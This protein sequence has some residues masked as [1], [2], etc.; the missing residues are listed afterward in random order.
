[1]DENRL[2]NGEGNMPNSSI[3]TVPAGV[4]IDHI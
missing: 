3:R 4:N 2:G 1:M